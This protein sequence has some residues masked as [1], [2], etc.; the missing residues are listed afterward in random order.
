M[1]ELL[2]H[3]CLRQTN[4]VLEQQIPL[5]LELFCPRQPAVLLPIQQLV[6]PRLHLRGRPEREHLVGRGA[7]GHDGDDRLLV[8]AV[9]VARRLNVTESSLEHLREAIAEL[10]QSAP[11]FIRDSNGDV[12]RHATF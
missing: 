7:T 11:R 6:H 10:L 8:R 5:Q 1:R 4:Q 3:V 12:D 2:E 9:G